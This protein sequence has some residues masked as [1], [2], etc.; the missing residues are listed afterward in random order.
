MC[1]YCSHNFCIQ[2]AGGT[3]NRCGYVYYINGSSPGLSTGAYL[4]G[5]GAITVT[6]SSPTSP[7]YI[8]MTPVPPKQEEKKEVLPED[9]TPY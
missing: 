4:G 2:C 3:C 6:P 5:A 9:L 7:G 8:R 1:G